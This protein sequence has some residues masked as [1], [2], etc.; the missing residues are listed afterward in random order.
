M[1]SWE[2]EAPPEI[3]GR[4]VHMVVYGSE[5]M[6]YVR[7]YLPR[8][9]TYLVFSV[10]MKIRHPKNPPPPPVSSFVVFNKISFLFDNKGDN[11]QHH[12]KPPPMNNSRWSYSSLWDGHWRPR[13]GQS[14]ICG[15]IMS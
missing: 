12:N 11:I 13:T 15:A 5:G 6:L 3:I 9:D 4:N 1:G 14:N 7:T 10:R 2:M 8:Y